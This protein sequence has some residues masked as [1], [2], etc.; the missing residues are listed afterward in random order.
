MSPLL[1]YSFVLTADLQRSCVKIV[2]LE[3]HLVPKSGKTW[4]VMGDLS[5]FVFTLKPPWPSYRVG[6]NKQACCYF[7]AEILTVKRMQCSEG[8]VAVLSSVLLSHYLFLP[9]LYSRSWMHPPIFVSAFSRRKKKPIRWQQ[10]LSRA[11]PVTHSPAVV[12]SSFAEPHS[13]NGFRGVGAV[14]SCSC[15]W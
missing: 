8:K 7:L 14:S 10:R 11:L 15:V 4:P 1:E 5:Y 2:N 13:F 3:I 12:S 9:I 6:R